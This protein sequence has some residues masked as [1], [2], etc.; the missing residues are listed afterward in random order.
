MNQL[1]INF[2]SIFSFLINEC[3]YPSYMFNKLNISDYGLLN[4]MK[5]YNNK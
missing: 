1:T 5:N 2:D 3:N 4:A